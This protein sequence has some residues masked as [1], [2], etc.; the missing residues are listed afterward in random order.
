MNQR[1]NQILFSLLRSA[2]RGQALTE[3]EKALFTQEQLSELIDIAKKHDVI[4][5]LAVG[6]K[7]N[8]LLSPQEIA[9]AEGEIFKAVFRYE[10]FTYELGKLCDALEKAEIPFMPLKG[11]VIRQYYKEPWMRTSC[12]ID[13]LIH[14]EDIEKAVSYLTENCEYTYDEQGTH[15]ISLH[16][17]NRVH[18][19][20]HYE[21]VEADWANASSTVLKKVWDTALVCKGYQYAYE[22]PDEMFYFYHIAHMVKHL[23]Q[24]GCGI[25][26]F[27]D[28]WVLDNM[29]EK[30]DQKRDAMLTQGNLMKFTEVARKMS[31]VWF[32]G[33]A[34]DLVSLQ[35]ESYIL[36]GGVY[37]TVQNRILFLQQ[38]RGGRLQYTLSKIFLPYDILKFHYPILQKYRWLT[39]FMEVRRWFKLMFCGHAKRVMGEMQYSASI[40]SDEANE[41]QEFLKNIGL[42]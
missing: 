35:M 39:P 41:T 12:D 4:H 17:P 20:L 13:I 9:N 27:L 16:S 28:I 15:D 25:R 11:S 1:T 36:Q 7:Q 10:G 40:S 24:G 23:E 2:I 8:S 3:Q 18:V 6:L 14:E 5:L 42:K 30:N 21:L 26:P 32:E 22:M 29:D 31:R 37:G 38:K 34:A 19:E 33:E